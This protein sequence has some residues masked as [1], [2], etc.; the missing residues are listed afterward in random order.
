M[1]TVVTDVT[2]A[3]IE[4]WRNARTFTAGEFKEEPREYGAL[5][6]NQRREAMET[7]LS[8]LSSRLDCSDFAKLALEDSKTA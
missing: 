1:N 8:A 5:Q 4:P 6:L 3:G 7:I 2:A